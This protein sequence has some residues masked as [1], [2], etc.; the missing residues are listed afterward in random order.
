MSRLLDNSVEYREKLLAKN[1]YTKNDEYRASHADA[2]SD[3]DEQGKGEKNGSIGGLTDIKQREALMAKN[4][5]S[6]NDP[7]NDSN[8]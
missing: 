6:F 1:K 7:Y 4:K 8:A 2:L 5:Y 3:G